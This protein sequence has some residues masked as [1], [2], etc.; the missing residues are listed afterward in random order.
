[1]LSRR[2]PRWH[3]SCLARR[4]FPPSDPPT[5]MLLHPGRPYRDAKSAA[6]FPTTFFSSFYLLLSAFY[7]LFLS[8]LECAV[9]HPMKDA[10]PEGVSR[11]KDLNVHLSLL[12]CAVTQNATLSA[13]E[14]AVTKT[15]PASPLEC[16]VPKKSGGR[17]PHLSYP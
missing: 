6:S 13:L 17:G 14:C 15:R 5:S 3:R 8:P 1:M 10:S 2:H 4:P 9:E 7:L 16:A 11:P 12:K